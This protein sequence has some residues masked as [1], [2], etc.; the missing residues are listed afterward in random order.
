MA[1][2]IALALAAQQVPAP[3]P[4][5]AAPSAEEGIVSCPGPVFGFLPNSDEFHPGTEQ[6][7]N[8]IIEHMNN[9]LWR[10]GWFSI[11]ALV[12]NPDDPAVIELIGR[13]Q[14]TVLRR[15]LERGIARERI[16]FATTAASDAPDLEDVLIIMSNVS[17]RTWRQIVGP[18]MVC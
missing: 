1:S 16:R 6:A 12:R 8:G 7:L 9:P 11:E 5:P 13:R 3:Q 17:G 14:R 15:L 10:H 18:G 4:Q 2:L